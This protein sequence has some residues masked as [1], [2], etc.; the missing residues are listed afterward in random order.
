MELNQKCA[1]KEIVLVCPSF[2]SSI[3]HSMFFVHVNWLLNYDSNCPFQ[4]HASGQYGVDGLPVHV[5]VV[6][7]SS[8][9][10]GGDGIIL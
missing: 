8:K 7:V 9:G 10:P 3:L 5:H 1:I 6:A 4:F 2:N